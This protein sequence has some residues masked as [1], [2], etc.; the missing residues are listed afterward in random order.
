MSTE[1]KAPPPPPLRPHTLEVVLGG[2]LVTL[3]APGRMSTLWELVFQAN[4]HEMRA[5]AAALG[6]CFEA[7]ESRTLPGLDRYTGQGIAGPSG[8]GEKAFEVIIA[9]YGADAFDAMGK[10]F[11]LVSD[12][13]VLANKASKAAGF[14]KPTQGTG[15]G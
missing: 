2:E 14:T 8:Y 13:A 4:H 15:T 5:R 11:A 6:I 3:E 7:G 1:P 10:A 12:R 9:E